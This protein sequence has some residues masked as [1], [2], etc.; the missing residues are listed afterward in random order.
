MLGRPSW[1]STSVLGILSRHLTLSSFLWHVVW[2]GSASWH[3]FSENVGMIGPMGRGWK[4]IGK[5]GRG[6]VGK[7]KKP[8]RQENVDKDRNVRKKW[9]I[10]ENG[11]KSGTRQQ[12]VEKN[13][14][15][16]DRVG[17]DRQGRGKGR[18][19]VKEKYGKVD[20]VGTHRQGRGKAG[21]S[22]KRCGKKIGINKQ[23]RQS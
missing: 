9:K 7:G 12:Q 5:A 20:W 1:E 15:K 22:N 13:R 18:E 4:M 2:S 11:A 8:K 10:V 17:K 6:T 14:E 21:K 16:I 19:T 23:S 3:V